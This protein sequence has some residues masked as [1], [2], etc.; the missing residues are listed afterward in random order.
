MLVSP[1][2]LIFLV[3][4]VLFIVWLIRKN[5][6]L[7]YSDKYH[8]V[9]AIVPAFNEEITIGRTITDLLSNRYIRKVIV[10]NDGSTDETEKA[11]RLIQASNEE[12]ISLVTQINTGK[13]GAINNGLNYVET[14]KV[15]LTDADIRIPNDH[16]LGYLIKAIDNG[17]DAVAGIPGSD[18][19]NINF[20]GKVRAS[21]KIFFAT[22]RKCGFEIIG[23]H[24]F[25]VSGSVGMYK[26][27]I[28]REV[29]FPKR[30]C[31]E[32]LD[33]TWELISR[34]YKIAQSAKAIVYSQEAANFSDDIKR[35]RR[36]ISGYAVCMR[37]HKGLL[38]SRFGFTVILF[39]F[40]IGLFGMIF[41]LIPFFL[42]YK[43]ALN[44]LMYWLTIMI[45]ASGYS[46]FRQ[47]KKWWLILYS[48][49]SILIVVIVFFCWFIWG[50]PSLVTGKEE[51][52]NKVRRY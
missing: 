3:F 47:G 23:G 18:L 28:L 7:E 25:C 2:F 34:G 16:G 13:A 19:D 50:I 32:D 52:W 31:V 44:G 41:M 40:L 20:L 26:T 42:D 29:G 30:T 38:L 14:E 11:V 51:G 15:F 22:F 17:A 46:A 12:R 8:S 45:F 33:L 9:D 21:I 4:L 43:S 5:A 49:M 39:N 6:E 36:W 37:I 1:R 24:P 48:P 35:W 10:V 27:E